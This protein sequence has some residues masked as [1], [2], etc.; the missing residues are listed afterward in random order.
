[1]EELNGDLH[2]P[3]LI[4]YVSRFFSVRC[5]VSLTYWKG[6][7]SGVKLSLVVPQAIGTSL[8]NRIGDSAGEFLVVVLCGFYRHSMFLNCSY[9]FVSESGLGACFPGSF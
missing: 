8:R 2:Q 4:R 3:S 7:I 9:F 6:F 1:M 5:L